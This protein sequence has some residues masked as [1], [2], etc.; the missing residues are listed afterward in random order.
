MPAILIIKTSSLGDVV[1][2]LPI[3]ADIVRNVPNA[4][5]DWVVEEAF[6]D[7]PAMH[8]SIRTVVP[9][10]LRRWRRRLLAPDTWR[11]IRR[12]RRALRSNHYD[13]V[14]DTQGLIKSAV[15]A[16]CANGPTAGQD[17]ASA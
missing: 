3:V 9:V 7:V 16:A 14:L 1:H 8:P 10:A 17:A 4:Q 2:N 12:V 6:A 5:I 15:L 11:E 13:L